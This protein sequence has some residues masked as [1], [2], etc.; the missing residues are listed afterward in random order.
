M[1]FLDLN[2]YGVCEMNE[3]QTRD[4]NGGELLVGTVLAIIGAC[5]YVYNNYEDFAEG[6]KEG[7]NSK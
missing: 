1:K 6:F 2:A 5:I 4:A 3:S 7:W